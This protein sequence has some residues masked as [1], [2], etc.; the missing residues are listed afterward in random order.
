[1]VNPESISAT[2]GVTG[3]GNGGTT[4]GHY[5]EISV[6]ANNSIA[7]RNWTPN[8]IGSALSGSITV[9]NT[10]AT[11][12]KQLTITPNQR[13]YITQYATNGAVGTGN[14]SFEAVVTPCYPPTISLGELTDKTAKI[15]YTYAKGAEFYNAKFA[16]T[17]DN[18][19]TWFVSESSTTSG[20]LNFWWLS[21]DTEYTVQA[22]IQG[23]D[24]DTA[25][26]N[27]SIVSLTFRT[28]PEYKLYGS[29]S[30]QTKQIKKLY[31]SV[32]GQ[33]KLIKKLY[34]SVNGV[35]KRIL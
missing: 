32:N 5:V 29:V 1:M 9:D 2:V 4:A 31:G 8:Y 20:T 23:Y 19:Q 12:N 17:Y 10:S 30:S 15:N 27:S 13:Y 33:T 14:L 6:C 34:G 3:W 26:T 24:G 11:P 18:G 7:T 16:Y 35:T 25:K 21:P 22:K 28:L